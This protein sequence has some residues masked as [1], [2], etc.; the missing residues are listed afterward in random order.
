MPGRRRTCSTGVSRSNL[1][2]S[3]EDEE[4][5]TAGAAVWMRFAGSGP[6]AASANASA[7]RATSSAFLPVVGKPSLPSTSFSSLTVIFDSV[8][9]TK[10]R[11]MIGGKERRRVAEVAKADR[12][13]A[14][15]DFSGRV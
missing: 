15:I 9:E 6:V 2:A 10:R 1:D 14:D 8:R 13:L 7:C 5:I 12:R 3:A 11:A 4:A